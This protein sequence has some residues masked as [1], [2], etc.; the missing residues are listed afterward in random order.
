MSTWFMNDPKGRYDV[1]TQL[2]KDE[3][4]SLPENPTIGTIHKLR[5]QDFNNF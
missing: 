1:R 4:Q 5:R 2:V 3:F